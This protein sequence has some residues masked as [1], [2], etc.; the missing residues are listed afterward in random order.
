VL[1]PSTTL[2]SSDLVLKGKLR[3]PLEN[4]RHPTFKLGGLYTCGRKRVLKG[5]VEEEK[6]HLEYE[7]LK[8]FIGITPKNGGAIM[9]AS[10]SIRNP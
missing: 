8:P 4:A 9:H 1:P 6:K 10:L 5:C 7:A 3:V 2:E